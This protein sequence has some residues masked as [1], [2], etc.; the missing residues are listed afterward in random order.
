M[1]VPLRELTTNPERVKSFRAEYTAAFRA[2]QVVD[3][4]P[5]AEG[6]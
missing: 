2:G 3:F 6:A 5:A 1:P 4:Q